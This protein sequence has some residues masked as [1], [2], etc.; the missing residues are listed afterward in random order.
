MDL[1]KILR[2]FDKISHEYGN[3][4]IALMIVAAAVFLFCLWIFATNRMPEGRAANTDWQ[5]SLEVKQ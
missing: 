5:T 4:L 2:Y 1:D 3:W